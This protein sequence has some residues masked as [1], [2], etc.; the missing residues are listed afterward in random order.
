MLEAFG[1]K[2]KKYIMENRSKIDLKNKIKDLL[3]NLEEF[4]EL[5]A[6]NLKQIQEWS[7]ENKCQQFKEFF[8]NNLK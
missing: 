5:S 6:E 7:W 4:K 2:Q 1:E 3:N 8:N